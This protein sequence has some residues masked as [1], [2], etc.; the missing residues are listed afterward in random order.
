MCGIYG[1]FSRSGFR[2][3]S[4]MIDRM[5]LAIAH[6]GPDERG[7]K[8]FGH[9]LIGNERLS[10]MDV[11]HGRQPFVSADGS[12]AVVQN[13]E[14]YN[15]VELAEELKA[16]GVDV[17]THCDTEVLLH[18]Y[19]EH[20]PDFV[21]R[22][23]GMFSI[24]IYDSRIDRL[25]LIRDRVG[26]KPLFV[27]E[28]NGC[29]FFASEIKSLLAAGIDRSIDEAAIDL[30]LSFNF[31]PPPRTM[32]KSVRHVMPGT[33]EQVSVGAHEKSAWWRLADN[34]SNPDED[35]VVAGKASLLG[36]LDDA[37]RLRM[38]C[39]VPYGAFLSGG[40]DSST[41][42]GLM[43]KHVKEPISTYSIG[44]HD[45]RFDETV[46]A[47][48]AAQRFGTRHQLRKLE[49]DC[50]DSWPE[51]I[52]YCDQPHG[53]V[54][55]VPTMALSSLAASEVKLVLTGDGG[56]ELFAGYDKHLQLFDQNDY[57][58]KDERASLEALFGS[59]TLMP[60]SLKQQ[61]CNDGIVRSSESRP[62]ELLA[63]LLQ[64][65]G[66]MDSI[67]QALYVD[68]MLLLPGNNLVKPD[69]MGMARSL[70]ARTPFL[71]YR[72]IE[73]A[74][75]LPGAEKIKNG[76]SKSC[77]KEVVEPLIGSNLTYRAKQ[78][79]TVP[80][81]EWFK[82]HLTAYVAEILGPNGLG[83]RGL[84]SQPLVDQL[85]E[86]HLSQRVNRTRELRA[87]IAIEHWFREVM[88]GE[89]VRRPYARR[90]SA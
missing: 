15:F 42:V 49:P 88:D 32:L 51:A 83:R 59:L 19:L 89:L 16:R 22:L 62:R 13:G 64:D 43:S 79:F 57:G 21:S 67:N 47:N 41:V 28:H 9:V 4:E 61:L 44:F 71:D 46:Y 69:R 40:I 84:F 68:C 74:F 39:D 33:L 70:E 78:M 10:I 3:Q 24:A 45:P 87:L 53:D 7:H 34:Q 65:V 17:Q 23:N 35:A 85:V 81:G 60:D 31:V 26:V 6:R 52:F 8:D 1:F 20:G 5:G 63:S 50:L 25:L 77:L 55:F 73:A 14:I 66:H 2:P 75:A 27:A 11:E 12:V 38:R 86:E 56:D 37:V 18:L 76:Q 80:I 36:V 30:F 58:G 72:M 82:S 48:E 29:V 54:S 90:A